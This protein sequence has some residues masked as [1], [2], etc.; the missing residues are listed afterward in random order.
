MIEIKEYEKRIVTS[1]KDLTNEEK[2][3]Y[4]MGYSRA[5]KEMEGLR[6]AI[7]NLATNYVYNREE[8]E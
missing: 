4:L 6:K 5:M 8:N 1:S 3:I 2:D 7:I